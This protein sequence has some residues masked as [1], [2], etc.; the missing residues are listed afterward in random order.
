ME[1]D[2]A[3]PYGPLIDTSLRVVTWNVWGRH[4]PWEQRWKAIGSVLRQ[5]DPD[6][7]ALQES[8]SEGVAG[9]AGELGRHHVI[10]FGGDHWDAS[11]PCAVLSRW[12]ITRH[13]RRG[14]A[15]EHGTSGGAVL[16]AEIDGPRGPLHLFSVIL[17]SFRPYDSVIRQDAVRDL[18]AFVTET[19]RGSTPAVICGDF[20]A[21][22]ESDE[23]RMLTGLTRPAAEKFFAYDAWAVA[24]DGGAG[25]TWSRRNPWAAPALFP[26]RRFDYILSVWPKPGGAGHPLHCEVIGTTEIAGVIPSDHYGVLAD[27]RY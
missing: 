17:G 1:I 8:W 19:G 7:V 12:P 14:L 16:F 9:L 26:E 3:Q 27:L 15:P 18:A 23:M 22:A 5:A 6:V 24:G 2:W 13:E 11:T 25:I 10:G 21:P 4:G 20:N